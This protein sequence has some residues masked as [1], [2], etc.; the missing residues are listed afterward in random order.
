MNHKCKVIRDLK[1]IRRELEIA[2]DELVLLYIDAT[3]IHIAK[4]INITKASM[5]REEQN[6][7]E[8]DRK[9]K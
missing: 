4:A 5:K 6:G 8:N 3:N 1:E 2:L 7:R 9:T